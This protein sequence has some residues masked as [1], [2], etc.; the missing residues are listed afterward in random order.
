[1]RLFFRFLVLSVAGSPKIHGHRLSAR[2]GADAAVNVANIDA[3]VS[4]WGFRSEA[5]Q[6]KR[7]FD[8]RR[9]VGGC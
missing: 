8:W 7:A 4:G 3:V 2:V 9:W 6:S 1:M 5:S